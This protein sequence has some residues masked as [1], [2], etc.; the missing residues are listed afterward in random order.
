MGL[1]ASRAKSGS[2]TG[3]AWVAGHLWNPA[4]NPVFNQYSFPN[5]T[6]HSILLDGRL[7]PGSALFGNYDADSGGT[8]HL[9]GFDGQSTGAKWGHSVDPDTSDTF[10]GDDRGGTQRVRIAGG[11]RQGIA[12][13]QFGFLLPDL[14]SGFIP[15]IPIEVFYHKDDASGGSGNDW[16]YLGTMGNVGMIHLHGISAAQELTIGAETW[17]AMPAVRKSNVGGVNQETRNMGIIYN[18]VV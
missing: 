11:M 9:E 16:H 8:V 1:R 4:G 14:G 2:W 10:T 12:I 3:G 15:K 17:I 5:S 7:S 6:K 13:S 18:K